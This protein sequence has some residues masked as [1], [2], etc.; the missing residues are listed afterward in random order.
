MFS[1]GLKHHALHFG[2]RMLLGIYVQ[3]SQHVSQHET[4]VA[5]QAFRLHAED[6]VKQRKQG[7]DLG[8]TSDQ[9]EAP[10]APLAA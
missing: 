1:S 9:A 6:F 7:D 10:V 8:L 4:I 5:H 2:G 3:G